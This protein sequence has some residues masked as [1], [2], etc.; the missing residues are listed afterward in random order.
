MASTELS[1]RIRRELSRYLTGQTSLRQFTKWL[2]PVTFTTLE[3]PERRAESD[4]IAEI[5]LRLAEY[6]NGDW[7]EEALRGLLRPLVVTYTLSL[8]P[9]DVR[10]LMSWTATSS[11]RTSSSLSYSSA[12]LSGTSRA[13]EFSS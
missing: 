6:S 13:A 4:L 12:T 10:Q 9:Q 3:K 1:L 5:E 11:T 8:V 2:A 7:T